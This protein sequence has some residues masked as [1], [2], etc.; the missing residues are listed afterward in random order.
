MSRGS[1]KGVNNAAT[2]AH[3]HVPLDGCLNLRD[4]GGYRTRDGREVRRRCLFRSSELYSLTD[5]D[6]GTLNEL[7]IRVVFDL[8]AGAER[9]A[10][11]SR[12]PPGVVLEERSTPSVR[13]DP[14]WT[15]EE[16]IAMGTLP[17]RDD[18]YLTDVYIRQ[19]DGGLAAELRRILELA[20][21]AADR[22]LLFHCAAGKDRTGL[23][24]AVLLGVLGVP[25]DTI[26]EDYELSTAYW[27]APRLRTLAAQLAEYGI[28]Q[29]RVRPLLEARTAVF[30][31]AVEHLHDRFGSYDTYAIE[32]LGLDTDL[33]NRLRSALTA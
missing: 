26:A 3:R 15:L 18:D 1:L 16:Q 8:R 24:A 29:E 11:P 25:D 27:A 32:G 6:L 31:R 14:P 20:L 4:L 23:A 13:T 21:E 17:E 28:E 30:R 10:R 9:A 22:P 2:F 5:A 7:G 33:P 19:L 12:L